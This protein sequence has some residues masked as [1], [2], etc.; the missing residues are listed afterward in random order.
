MLL[1]RTEKTN[2]KLD[3]EKRGKSGKM[4]RKGNKDQ[5]QQEL[6]TYVK[7]SICVIIFSEKVIFLKI[8]MHNIFVH[9]SYIL[10]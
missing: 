8:N 3:T 10:L 5:A 1:E 4:W 7:L 9:I 6:L 2:G